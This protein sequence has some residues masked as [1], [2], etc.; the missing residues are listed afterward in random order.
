M[1]TLFDI[2]I[3]VL[4]AA[5]I[6][7]I[8]FQ[9]FKLP[10]IIGYIFIG[11]AIHPFL[12][13][14]PDITAIHE[15]AEFGI[16]FLLFTIGQEFSLEKLSDIR[17]NVVGIG[18]S[19]ILLTILFA[20]LL[21]NFANLSLSFSIVIGGVIAMSSSAIVLKQLSAQEQIR[22]KHGKEIT[23]V[24]LLQDIAAIPFFILI[25]TLATE[26]SHTLLLPI[27]W[28]LGRGFLATIAI[29]GIGQYILRPLFR[30]MMA[31]HSIEIFTLA[32]LLVTLGAAWLTE[33]L[34]L[35]LAF[36]AFLAGMMLSETEYAKEIEHAVGS[37]RDILLGLFFVSIGMLF[38][39][40]QF[41]IHW[42]FVI[43]L[44]AI[45]I[46]AKGFLIYLLGIIFKNSQS[47]ALRTGLIL[48]QGSEFSFAII[49]LA[50]KHQLLVN[51]QLNIVLSALILSMLI[52]PILILYNKQVVAFLTPQKPLT[53]D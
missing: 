37:F 40:H 5:F 14:L 45:L 47:D 19:E 9:F 36:G 25:P 29:I 30:K 4:L 20:I 41:I 24:L 12:R 33:H 38:D 46:L 32:T 3:I 48:A 21:G 13:S 49:L 52:S 44:L 15:L 17:W 1:I 23:A 26:G 50:N 28:G 11:V 6:V 35:S 43:S 10:I 42:H 39:W 2:I 27:V 53:Q 7:A 22:T 8:L 16:V 31:F 51:N 18:I 34:G